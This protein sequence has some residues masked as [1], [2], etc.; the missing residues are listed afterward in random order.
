MG[1]MIRR[2]APLALALCL[3]LL[4][5]TPLQQ[6]PVVTTDRVDFAAGGTIR[7]EGSV[8]EL[9]IEGWDQPQV[10][11]TLT[12]FDYVDA[13]DQD[14]E[15]GKLER[16][17]VK[18]EKRSGNELV[19]TTTLPHRNFFVRKV[20][21]ETDS[22]MHYRVMVPRDSHLI[23]HHGNGDVVVYDVG[24][25]IEATAG[26][27]AVVVQLD[28]PAQYAIDARSRVGEVY[29]DYGGK[30]RAP[31]LIGDGLL[32]S[33]PAPAHRVFVRVGIGDIDIVK[34]GPNPIAK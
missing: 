26:V 25:D 24:G 3:P 34:M 21:G 1:I 14:R 6:V 12:R 9:S 13:V 27:G 18:T 16:I 8:G 33:A 31:L 5:K 32:A 23:I 29:S 10:Q 15:K 30:Y 11:V 2:V 20:R 22:A 17:T 19:I 4:P 28:D 7:F